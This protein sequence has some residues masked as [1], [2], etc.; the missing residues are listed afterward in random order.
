[1]NGNTDNLVHMANRIGEF[2]QAMPDAA[3]GRDGVAEH[4]RK[5]WAP[6]MRRDL[7]AHVDATQG[8]GLLPIVAAALQQHR[9]ALA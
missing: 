3:E 5:F 2:F 9:Q 1:M 6:A 7:L 4:L 8:A